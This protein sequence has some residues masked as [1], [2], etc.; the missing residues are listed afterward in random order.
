MFDSARQRFASP[1]ESIEAQELREDFE[2]T[3]Y[4]TLP[5]VVGREQTDGGDLCE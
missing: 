5:R 2:Q 4:A 1:D 3:A